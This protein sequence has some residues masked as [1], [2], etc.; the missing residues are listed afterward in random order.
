MGKTWPK[1]Y[2]YIPAKFWLG[3]L[4]TTLDESWPGFGIGIYAWTL[5]TYLQL[6]AAGVLCELTQTF[7]TSGIVLAHRNSLQEQRP[8][9]SKVLLICLKAELLPSPYAQLHVVQNPAVAGQAHHYLPHWPQPGLVPRDRDRSDRF[10]SIAFFGHRHNLDPLFASPGWAAALGQLGLTWRPRLS[11]NHWFSMDGIHPQWH[12][13]S[14]VDAVVAV[15][16]WGPNRYSNKP[17]TKLYNAWLAGVP[18]FLGQETAYRAERRSP[19]DYV[20][21][22]SPK[23]LL[24]QLQRLK[25]NPGLRRAMVENGYR[26][27]TAI[28]PAVLTQRWIEFLETVAIPAYHQ[29][30]RNPI[31]RQHS[32]LGHSY[33]AAMTARIRQKMATMLA[34]LS[35][36]ASKI[37]GFSIDSTL[38]FL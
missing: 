33:A 21:V 36:D 24:W 23:D 35:V 22:R 19:L 17:A 31:W 10:E 20:E 1:I 25:A 37:S 30:C 16:G 2:F 8:A 15:R 11:T 4:P 26:R 28:Q 27:S 12:D 3:T 9:G 18:A 38:D 14:D 34:P 29:W 6:K 5:Q 13:Y 7:P 32:L